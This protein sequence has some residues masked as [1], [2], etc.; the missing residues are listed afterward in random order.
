M[1]IHR[2]YNAL[3]GLAIGDAIAWPSMYKRSHLLP[4][5]TRRMRRELDNAAEE[6]NT[7]TQPMP[8]SLNRPSEPFNFLAAENTEWG[9]FTAN[10]LLK[11]GE[12]NFNKALNKY[13]KELAENQD[14]LKSSISVKSVLNN[15]S[16]GC[17]PPESGMRNPHY[18]DD[19]AMPRAVFIGAMYSGVPETAAKIAE[20]DASVTNYDD[21]LWAAIFTASFISVLCGGRDMFYALEK[22]ARFLP[23][24]S[25][26]KRVVD[27]SIEISNKNAP[28]FSLLPEF[29]KI[30]VNKEY[31]YGISAPET[32]GLALAIT[33]RLGRDFEKAVLTANSLPKNAE[34][35]P[36]ITGAFAGALQCERIEYKNWDE[37]ISILQGVCIPS[38]KGFNYLNFI[39]QIAD[40]SKDSK[41]ENLLD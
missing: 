5:W 40:G 35:L 2:I 4:N 6:S 36:A 26:I 21:G 33:L 30:I 29:Q 17:M 18:F 7:L 1:T 27:Q 25:W 8:F 38:L 14:E 28:V 20:A 32:L 16:K 23:N 39:S 11:S 24:D 19:S 13:W 9:V 15:I 37:A 41:N 10:I 12:D 34:R 3:I 22:S 31:S